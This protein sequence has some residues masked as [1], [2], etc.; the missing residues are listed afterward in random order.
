MLAQVEL[1]LDKMHIWTSGI[2]YPVFL[3]SSQWKEAEKPDMSV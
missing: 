3:I 2:V 1:Y